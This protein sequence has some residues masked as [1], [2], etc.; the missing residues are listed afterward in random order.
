[1]KLICCFGIVK[2]EKFSTINK[3]TLYNMFESHKT[4]RFQLTVEKTLIIYI[5]KTM[6][7]IKVQSHFFAGSF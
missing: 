1:M 2:H 6:N 4:E 7:L 3:K 5:H